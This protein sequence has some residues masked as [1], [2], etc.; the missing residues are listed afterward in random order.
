MVPGLQDSLHPLS[1]AGSVNL[2]LALIHPVEDCFE[3][4]LNTKALVWPSEDPTVFLLDP[5]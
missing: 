4:S 5:V 1:H 3:A 2:F